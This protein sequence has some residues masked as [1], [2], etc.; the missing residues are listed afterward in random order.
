[1]QRKHYRIVERS[2]GGHGDLYE[3][4]QE[5]YIDVVDAETGE[6][7]LTFESQHRAS[8]EGGV[9]ANWS[10]TGV[11]RVELGEDGMSVRVFRY[12][13]DEPENVR[14]PTQPDRS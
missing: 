13:F 1:M 9:W 11:R 7:V 14:I 12:G 6:V 3:L 8:L 5:D 2:G 4:E 10:H